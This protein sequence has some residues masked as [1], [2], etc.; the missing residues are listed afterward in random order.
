MKPTFIL[1]TLLLPFPLIAHPDPRHTLEHLEEHLAETPDDAGLL[2]EKA[3]LLLA[4]GQPD[5]AQPVIERLLAI[6]PGMPENLLLDARVSLAKNGPST[7]TKASALTLAHPEFAPGWNLLARIEDSRARRDQAIA[8][9]RRYLELARKPA[10][11][12]VLTCA[13]W[14]AEAGDADAAI[15]ILDQGLAKLGVLTGLHQKAIDLELTL[16]RHDSALRRVDT[17]AARFRPSVELSLRRAEIL[18]KADRPAEAAAACDDALALLE[19]IPAKRKQE[20]AYR[21]KLELI[22]K[23]K[24]ENLAR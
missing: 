8:A 19:S 11:G 15:T 10:P 24:S 6:A 13:T 14:I 3:D 23:R 2:R 18:E 4:T 22:A 16:G 9:K 17:L 7:F 21:E 12:D 5:L 1:T 20:D